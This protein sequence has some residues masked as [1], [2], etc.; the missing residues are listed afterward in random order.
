MQTGYS[1]WQGMK[2][3]LTCKAYSGKE[4]LNVPKGIFA[5]YDALSET[6]AKVDAVRW[7]PRFE[8]PVF[9]MQGVYDYQTSYN[10]AKR[11]YEKI[12]AVEKRFYTF[13]HCAHSP[14]IEEKEQFIHILKNEVLS[15]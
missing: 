1:Q 2:E 3:I 10:E 7:A 4:R 15:V 9:I 5:T 14:F 8:I 6:M 12:E 11:F 13:D